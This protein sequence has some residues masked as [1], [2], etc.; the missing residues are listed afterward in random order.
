MRAILFFFLLVFLSQ[1]NADGG[2]ALRSYALLEENPGYWYQD[3]IPWLVSLPATQVQVW[4]SDTGEALNF[5]LFYNGYPISPTRTWTL[6]GVRSRLIG[7]GTW[8]TWTQANAR[9]GIRNSGTRGQLVPTIYLPLNMPGVLGDAIGTGGQLDISGHQTISFSGVSH[10]YPNRVNVEGSSTSLFPD[11]KMEQELRVRL[12]GTIGEKIHVAVDHDSERQIGSDYSVSLSYDGDEDEIIQSIELGDV[13]L[14][15]TGP[16]FISYS[17]PHEGLF[18]AKLVAQA[19]PFD[20]TAIASKEGS[21]T[22]SSDFVGQA[23]L[24]TDSILDIRPADNYFFRAFPDTVSAVAFDPESIRVFIDDG[25][26]T[27]NAETGAIEGSWFV[28]RGSGGTLT[29]PDKWWDELQPGIEADYVLVD[30]GRTIRFLSPVN[31]NYEIGISYVPLGG[32]ARVGSVPVDGPYDLLCIKQSNPLPED[33][34]GYPTWAYEMRNYYFLGANNIVRESFNCDVFLQRAGEDPV[35]T[36]DGVPFTQLLGLDS[37]GDGL[38]YDEE[39]TMDWENGF[40]I[41]PENRPFMSDVLDYTNNSIYTEKNPAIN[42]SLYYM[43]VSYRAASTTYSLGHMGI[44][45]GSERVTLTVA[46]QARTLTRDTDYSI[47]YEVGLLTLMGEAADLAQD[48]A[49]TLRVTFEYIP[50]FSSVSKTLLGTR[51]VYNIGS[52]SW[53]GGTMMYES[54]SSPEDRPRIEEGSFGTTVFDMDMHLEA[55]PEFLTDAVNAIPLI[56]TEAESKVVLSGEVAVSLPA[57]ESKAWLDDM[58]GSESS[59]PLGQS[60]AA[61]F[62]PSLPRETMQIAPVGDFRWYNVTDRWSLSDIVPG[63]TSD[64]ASRYLS[65]ILQFVFTPSSSNPTSSW[66]GFQRCI[67]RYGAD[68]SSKTHLSLYVRPTGCA[69]DGNLYI[70]LGER[71]DEDTYWLQRVGDDL[72]RTSNGE[73]DT[74]DTNSDGIRS[75]TEDTGLDTLM[76]VDEPGYSSSN[77]DPNQDN[78]TYNAGD[79]IGVRFLNINN[80][81]NNGRLD[82]EDLNRNGVLDRANTFFRIRVPLNDPDYIISESPGGWLLIQIPLGDSTLVTVPEISDGEPTWEKITY[83]RI[84]VDGFTQEDTLEFYD[85]GLVGNRWEPNRISPFEEIS[86]P[87][88]PEELFTVSVV[89]NRQN[90]DY[91]DNPPPGIDPGD[92]ENG[93]LKLE[94]SI[95][96]DCEQ[97]LSGHQGLA[98]QTFY[99]NESYTA[100]RSITF[101]YRGSTDQGQ[102]FLQLGRDSLNYY[103]ITGDISSIWQRIEVD[104]QDLVDLKLLKDQSGED[105]LRS[106]NLAVVGNPSLSEVLML[107]VGVRNQ[108]PSPLTSRVWV[109]DIVL[110]GH[111]LDPGNAHRITSE[112]DMADLLSLSGDYRM[113]D[114]DFHGLGKTSGTGTTVTRYSAQST[115]NIDRFT[116]PVWNW[117]LPATYAWSRSFSEPRYAR[118][119]DVR[120]EGDETWAYRTENNRWDTS[121]QWRR[122]GRSDAFAGR[123]FLDPLHVRHAMGR[124]WGRSVSTRDSLETETFTVDYDLSLGRMSLIRVPLLEDIRLRPTRFGFGIGFSRGRNVMWDIAGEDTVLTRNNTERTLDA[125]GNVSFNPWKGLT[126]S[127][128]LAVGRDMYYPWDEPETGIN[129]G[130]EVSRS[131]NAG[132]SQEINF[133]NYLRPRLSWDVRYSSARLSPHTGSPSDTLSRP[134]VGADLTQRLN[135]RVGLA[136][137]IRSIARLRDERLDEEAVTGSPRWL[138]S[139]MERWADRITD[140]NIVY[141]QSRGTDYK[142]VPF[143]PSL[144]YQFGLDPLLEGLDPYSRTTSNSIQISGGYR[145]VNTMSIRAEYSDSENRSFYSGFWNRTDNTTWPS[146]SVSWSGLERYAPLS[147]LRTG[148]VSSGYR[149]ETSTTS[150]IENDSLT[151]I[152][153]TETSR[154]SPLASFTGSFDNKV[155]ITLSDNMSTTETRNFTGTSARVRSNTNSAQFKLSY[156]FSAPGGIAIPIPLLDRLRLSFQ[157]DLTTSL[158]ITRSSSSSEIIGGSTGESQI[159][160][161]KTEWRIEPSASYDFGTVTASMT[162]IYGWKTDKVNDQYDQKDVGLNISVT[163]NF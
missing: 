119:S 50:F 40:M 154:W 129:V 37:N 124:G 68:F 95:S 118:N 15:I 144:E 56:N 142:D 135:L 3:S 79:P 146:V 155:Q 105:E 93:D 92:D 145:P 1:S 131:Q 88:Q 86:I 66:G 133:W 83:A 30:S 101:P 98:R 97:I 152:S 43:R 125:D 25:D 114:D 26:I 151:P 22:E 84:W 10:I 132:V 153:E 159:Q 34:E 63:E 122:N 65:S 139:K 106:G 161:D 113:V 128:S 80:C 14:S 136:H 90:Q 111:Y 58:E 160:S 61:W 47:I 77:L 143:M 64:E 121:V 49:N 18:G 99:S 55:R 126:G 2:V 62:Y 81:E 102:V 127:Y 6:S 130:R 140:P 53:L 107:A 24:V 82:T 21:S 141:S 39:I 104:L 148:S 46:G 72:I 76:S 71:I 158:S 87:V 28:P 35:S 9:N 75:S 45:E 117:S 57:G 162:G 59:F 96:L 31:S 149:L 12:D 85:M 23:S 110:K 78:Y 89:N 48:P 163:I 38:M 123:Y 27:N 100:Y 32:G 5:R 103:E 150:R 91:I 69:T 42:K 17:I 7:W 33:P 52:N 157:S 54:A 147:F 44:V 16:E 67:E 73:L 60:R 109:D 120:L 134:D 137:A 112:I 70:D 8:K 29:A 116:P 13:N 138:L 11:L 108:S 156:A 74:E 36:Q 51:L 4:A 19:G 94:Q 115:F 41:F 20:F